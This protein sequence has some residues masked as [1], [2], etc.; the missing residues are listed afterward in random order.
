MTAG[1]LP[2]VVATSAHGR[3]VA[4]YYDESTEP[5]YGRLWDAD[6]IHFGLFEATGRDRS[7]GASLKRMTAAVVGP[8]R[9]GPDDLVID[10]GCGVGG[11]AIDLSHS[12]GCHVVGL[13][14]SERQVAI[15]RGRAARAGLAGRVRFAAADCSVTLPFTD[16]SVDVIVSIEAAC[17]FP[18]R[19]RF[20]RECAR[21][22]KSGGRLALSDWLVNEGSEEPDRPHAVQRLCDAWLLPGLETRATWSAMLDLAGFTVLDSLDFA[23][24]V[25]PNVVLLERS[26]QELQ[27][28][29]ATC[30]QERRALH[31]LWLRQLDT[32]IGA[33]RR[34]WFTVGRLFAVRRM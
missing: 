9:I 17:H 23:D 33:W 16:R 31:A 30:P 22:L 8:A 1:P 6:D 12:V 15:A 11:A 24:D 32:L 26:R 5:F 7:L 28:E 34:R 19:H 4:A 21:V 27:L 2:E 29:Y 13:T 25:L 20:A 14:V 10:A 3:R 18:D